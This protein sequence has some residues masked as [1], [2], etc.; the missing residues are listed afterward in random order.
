MLKIVAGVAVFSGTALARDN[1]CRDTEKWVSCIQTL[2]NGECHGN[3]VCGRTCGKCADERDCYDR[4]PANHNFLYGYEKPASSIWP[5]LENDG[6]ISYPAI[7]IEIDDNY[8]F[9]R[10]AISQFCLDVFDGG[11]C[12]AFNMKIKY[13]KI[14]STFED[15]GTVSWVEYELAGAAKEYCQFTCGNCNTKN[16]DCWK[17][18]NSNVGFLAGLNIAA[19]TGDLDLGWLTETTDNVWGGS[20]WGDSDSTYDDEEDVAEDTDDSWGDSFWGDSSWGWRKR[21]NAM[22]EQTEF[23]TDAIT[24]MLFPQVKDILPIQED[25]KKR[26]IS[27][28]QDAGYLGQE[29]TG[30]GQVEEIKDNI[31]YQGTCFAA[32][33][34]DESAKEE[35]ESEPEAEEGEGEDPLER[36]IQQRA[37]NDQK[38]MNKW[39]ESNVVGAYYETDCQYI[40]MPYI[41]AFPQMPLV[42]N[43]QIKCNTGS[44]VVEEFSGMVDVSEGVQIQCS[45]QV[46]YRQYHNVKLNEASDCHASA[47]CVAAAGGSS[48]CKPFSCAAS[49]KA[50]SEY[51]EEVE[52]SEEAD[53]EYTG[54]GGGWQTFK[55][56]P[57]ERRDKK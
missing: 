29:A 44:P 21:R 16:S 10:S 55:S 11:N 38:G 12:E 19:E 26:S 20:T 18:H 47:F 41:E 28:A 15:Y 48:T 30:S 42:Y 22:N 57:R 23:L 51:E 7:N 50:D 39:L 34:N 36:I 54:W 24:S 17:K 46:N 37:A 8:P 5:N 33:Q 13:Q 43:C 9:D 45:K 40:P 25:R 52:E 49:A 14:V 31:K 2:S 6:G 53:E 56:I 32:F 3:S 27:W 4:I 35:E 1:S